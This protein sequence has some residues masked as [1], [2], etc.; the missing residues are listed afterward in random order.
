MGM[1]LTY[2]LHNDKGEYITCFDFGWQ[3]P[4]ELT[5]KVLS[6]KTKEEQIKAVEEYMDS[7]P[8]FYDKENKIK[9]MKK[10]LEVSNVVLGMM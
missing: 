10:I 4:T 1:H 3:T 2:D 8:D 5:Y 9:M 7:F 6:F